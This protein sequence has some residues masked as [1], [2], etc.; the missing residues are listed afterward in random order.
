MHA[1]AEIGRRVSV[2][3]AIVAVNLLGIGAA[4]AQNVAP[5][6]SGTPPTTATPGQAYLFQ[7]TASDA[8]DDRISYGATGVPRWA[9]FDRKSGRL[10][11][12]PAQRD[13]G[14]SSNVKISV[15]DGKLIASLPPFTLEVVASASASAPT[16]A[17][18]I[19]GAPAGTAREK[20]LYTF[21]PQAGDADGDTLTFSV[22]NKPSWATFTTNSGLL[23]GIPPAGSAGTYSNIVI[24]V[25]DGQSTRSLPAFGIVVATAANS[26]PVIY[27]VPPTSV[28]AGNRYEFRPNAS[29]PDGQ[30]PTFSIQNLPR[31]ARFDTATGTLAGTPSNTDAT[32]YPS[33]VISASDGVATSSLSAFS[34]TVVATNSP[35]SIS[36]APATSAAVGQAYSF[37]PNASDPDGQ[38]LTFSIVNRPSWAQFDTATGRLTGT[39]GTANVGS[40]SGIVISATDG[41]DSVSLPAFS[42][43]VVNP[44]PQGSATLSWSPPTSNVDG[45]PV[46]NLAGYRVKYGQQAS[47]LSETLSIPSP[48]ITSVVIENL[49]TGTWYFAVSAYTTANIES[50]LSNLAQ[51]TL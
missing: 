8:N 50:D 20:E 44:V 6:I 39:P 18:W 41:Q 49:S 37:I 40:T 23:S 3:V 16:S 35:P 46:T 10:Y 31:W 11:G 25:S 28:Q 5:V 19:S 51:K 42:L 7:P 48:G 24:S 38:R 9:R 2:L 43:A 27:G 12:T 29:D 26:A 14:K 33:I 32:V 45:T 34:I 22:A 30:T 17:P 15:S 21:L 36:G 13:V 47:N 1:R 4:H